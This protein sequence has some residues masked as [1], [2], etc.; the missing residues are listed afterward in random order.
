[1]PI[2]PCGE[3]FPM[4]D[5]LIFRAQTQTEEEGIPIQRSPSVDDEN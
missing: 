4:R 1:M 2:N 5:P 3:R